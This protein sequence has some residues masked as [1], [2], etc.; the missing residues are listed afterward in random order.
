MFKKGR[1]PLPYGMYWLLRL[2]V[3]APDVPTILV[4]AISPDIPSASVL[5]IASDLP[6]DPD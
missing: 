5:S 1:E 2:T 4:P 3:L 6:T